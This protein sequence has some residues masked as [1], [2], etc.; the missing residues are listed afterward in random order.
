MED[1]DDYKPFYS[2]IKQN[3]SIYILIALKST[4]K[5]ALQNQ[6]KVKCERNC[7]QN[8]K[9]LFISSKMSI[10]WYVFCHV[11][12]MW[13][14]TLKESGWWCVLENASWC[15]SME[16]IDTVHL[17]DIFINK[18]TDLYDWYVDFLRFRCSVCCQCRVWVVD[19]C[20]R[21]LFWFIMTAG[22]SS[23]VLTCR[24]FREMEV[25]K[26]TSISRL[27]LKCALNVYQLTLVAL[28]LLCQH[29]HFQ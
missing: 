21:P 12:V 2:S 16:S 3:Q 22:L 10:C 26:S 24:K 8:L 6:T 5:N 20:I 17:Q 15:F 25:K 29:Q 4:F 27:T 18:W 14:I 9:L 13:S 7:N 28:P 11:Y 19:F 23:V 1:P